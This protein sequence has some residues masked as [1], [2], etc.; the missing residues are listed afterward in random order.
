MI[1]LFPIVL[2]AYNR[3]IHVK[4]V[5]D[6]LK[7][8]EL[9]SESKLIVFIDGPKENATIEE[10]QKIQDV[11]LVVE[12]EKWCKSVDIRA[13]EKNL[14]CGNS[15]IQGITQ[16]LQNHKALIV[17]EDDIITSPLF[18]LFMNRTLNF[19]RDYKSVFSVSGA[20]LPENK[21]KLPKNY[22][23]DVYVSLRQLNHGWGTWC[24]RWNFVNWD[25]TFVKDFIQ[26]PDQVNAFNRG[27]DDLTPMLVDQA[28]G[29]IDTWDIQFAFSH[30][31]NH[32]VSIIPR[33][34][35][36][37]YIG[38]DGSGT[39]HS[40]LGTS[41]RFDLEKAIREPRLL[42]VIYEDSRIINLFFNAFTKR[43]RPLWQKAVNR[44]ARIMG[45]ENLFVI[46][47]KIYLQ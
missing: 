29:R 45:G 18:L 14:G 40:D 47:K 1:D 6:A 10:H 25:L 28:E 24:D 11:I 27:G 3:P 46:K 5:L 16:V 42:D 20:G 12:S 38:G 7:V 17:L 31:K 35:Y 33:Y 8:N 19:Y 30:F 13:S 4:Q 44:F 15:I 37:D 23:Y 36:T 2:F 39:H 43:K 21:M 32:A 9:A 41:Q 34:S 26:D 22:D